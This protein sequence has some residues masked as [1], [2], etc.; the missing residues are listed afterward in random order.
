MFRDEIG[1]EFWDVPLNPQTGYLFHNKNLRWFLSGRIALYA[2]IEDILSSRR[3]E[4]IYLPSWCCESMVLPF[5]ENGVK[6]KFYPVYMKDKVFTVDFPENGDAILVM[7][8]FG[9]NC[10]YKFSGFNGIV[11]HDITHSIPRGPDT[12][13]DYV[14][15]SMRKWFGI[16]TGGFAVKQATDWQTTLPQK[17]DEIYIGL[18]NKAFEQKKNYISGSSDNRDYLQTFNRAEDYLDKLHDVFA[19]DITDINIVNSIDFDFIAKKRKENAAYLIENLADLVVFKTVGQFDVP[20]F[21]PILVNNRDQLRRSFIDN[22]IYCP[23]HW[24]KFRLLECDAKCVEIYDSE[25]SLIC[26]Q[27]YS[28]QDMQTIIEIIKGS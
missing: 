15:G 7:D 21:V 4:N 26:D 20:L 27:R 3:L 25:I 12:Y 9:Y 23:V 11:I 17:S 13:G 19:A 2:I 1:S 10:D 22:K 16:A 6:V 18:R 8:Y 28:I 14:F 5:I 24:P